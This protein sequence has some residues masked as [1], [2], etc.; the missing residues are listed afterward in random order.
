MKKYIDFTKPHKIVKHEFYKP[1]YN[2]AKALIGVGL[3]GVCIITPFTNGFILAIVPAC[4][5]Q[6]PINW[7]KLREN[8]YVNKLV[9]LRLRLK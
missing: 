7:D 5:T 6:T 8:K 1:K 2:Y 3:I 9:R 4:I